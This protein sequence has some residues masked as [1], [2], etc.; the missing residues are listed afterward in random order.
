VHLKEEVEHSLPAT[1]TG[2]LCNLQNE[3]LAD[4]K[5]RYNHFSIINRP[6]SNPEGAWHNFTRLHLIGARH[7]LA[8]GW[9]LIGAW[10][11]LAWHLLAPGETWLP[12]ECGRC[13]AP[14][15]RGTYW[16]SRLR[17]AES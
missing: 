3:M 11:L 12:A 2:E 14:I 16:T 10:H 6:W 1:E 13:L 9:H 4:Q 5:L 17:S 7:L 8:T 15:G